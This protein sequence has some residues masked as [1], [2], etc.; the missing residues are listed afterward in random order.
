MHH[1][2]KIAPACYNQRKP[3][4]AI[5]TQHSQKEVS[6]VIKTV[7][8][9]HKNR[10]MDQRNNIESLEINPCIYSQ[11]TFDKQAKN[12]RQKDSLFNKQCLKTV[13]SQTEE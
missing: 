8:Q 2:E 9:C 3:G 12:T 7:W 11:L 6:T 5:K 4:A 10:H 13:Y 1:D